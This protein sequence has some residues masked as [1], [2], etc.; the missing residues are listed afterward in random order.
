MFYIKKLF[1]M[2]AIDFC[3]LS[4]QILKE[5]KRGVIK[6]VFSTWKLIFSISKKDLIW[7]V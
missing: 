4:I 7:E 1:K 5:F 3:Q 6:N 2:V